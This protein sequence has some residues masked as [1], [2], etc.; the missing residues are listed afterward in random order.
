MSITSHI[1]ISTTSKNTKNST[2]STA[3]KVPITPVSITSSSAISERIRPIRGVIRSEYRQHRNTS[4]AVSTISGIEIVSTATWNRTPS[5]GI[6][7][8]SVSAYGWILPGR[9]RAC[10]PMV[11]DPLRGRSRSH[12]STADP[13]STSPDTTAPTIAA[14]WSAFGTGRTQR[15]TAARNGNPSRTSS[16]ALMS[17]SPPPGSRAR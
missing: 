1:G 11:D 16:K 4:S 8:T 17:R 9:V 12:H 10:P 3:E 6:Q 5:A 13:T 7:D 2:R 14:S 15:T